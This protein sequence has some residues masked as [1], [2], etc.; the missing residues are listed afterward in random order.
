M[1]TSGDINQD[2]GYPSWVME[3][4]TNAVYFVS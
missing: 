4:T 1:K 2:E 3:H